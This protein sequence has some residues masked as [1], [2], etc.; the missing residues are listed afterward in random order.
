MSLTAEQE[1]IRKGKMTASRVGVLMS[2]NTP[3]IARL[4]QE[5]IGEIAPENLDDVWPVQLG[6]ATEAVQLDWYERK[7]K[8]LLTHRGFV[9]VHPRFD[10]AAATIDGF[11]PDVP[12]PVECKHVGGWEPSEVIIDRYQPQ[13]H[14]QAWCMGTKVWALSCIRGAAEPFVD[15]IDVD[16]GYLEE[17]VA[18]A[19]HF[20]MC[21]ALHRPP[22]EMP[23]IHP[24][25]DP[26]AVVDLSTNNY[27]CELANKWLNLRPAYKEYQEVNE[28]L[29]SLVPD[30]AKRAW[31][32]GIKITRARNGALTVRKDD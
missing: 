18:R 24:P 26:D 22:V 1:A 29:K 7:N 2:G 32:A 5:M 20:M 30:T 14:W 15:Y 21:V 13:G 11:D 4:Y 9:S 28:T 17:M 8:R 12:C 31:G 27:W 16:Q 19:D 23:K 6:Q 3:G 10:W 25:I